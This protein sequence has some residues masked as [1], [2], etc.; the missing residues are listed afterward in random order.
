MRLGFVVANYAPHVGGVETH[1]ARV[2]DA[3]AG[4]G[5]QVRVWAVAPGAIGEIEGIAVH[6]LGRR[7]EVGGA[8]A[9]PGISGLREDFRWA[10]HLSAHTRFFPATWLAAAR[11][12]GRPLLLTEH[13]GGAVRTGS[14]AVNGV[15]A[16]ID[17]TVARW[18]VR[19]ATQL[20]AVSEAARGNLARISGDGRPIEVVGNGVDVPFWSSALQPARRR[21]VYVGRLVPEKGWRD[22]LSVVERTRIPADLVGGGPDL[23]AARA[24]VESRGLDVQVHG[25]LDREGVRE[26]VSGAV[27]VNPSRAAE[28]LQTTLLEAAAAGSRIVTTQVGGA[29]EVAAAGAQV[30][31]A[32]GVDALARA[33]M[34]VLDLP[35]G[36]ADLSGFTW[37]AV[38]GRYLA[39][40]AGT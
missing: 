12:G 10:T 13:G 15:G 11:R 39:V 40:L 38:A 5:I 22:F 34:E 20:L 1:V 29:A 17:R 33:V 21:L 28:G 9:V 24:I 31:F 16:V 36:R 30:R 37:S 4:M 8:W 18:A 25:Q 14:A 6:P 35:A 26:L 7:L 3:L 32:A 23:P 27:L 19:R 2:A